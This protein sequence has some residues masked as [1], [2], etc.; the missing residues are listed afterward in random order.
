MIVPT[1]ILKLNAFIYFS[2]LSII[3]DRIS[4]SKN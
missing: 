3:K 2:I 1:V 4:L